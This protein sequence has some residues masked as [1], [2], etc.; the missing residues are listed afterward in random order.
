MG[1]YLPIAGVVVSFRFEIR[2]STPGFSVLNHPPTGDGLR[3]S[4]VTRPATNHR[5]ADKT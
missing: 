1:V 5:S 2:V 3:S 4:G